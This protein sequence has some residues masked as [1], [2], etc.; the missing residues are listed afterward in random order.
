MNDTIEGLNET[1]I[2]KGNT[3]G[4]MKLITLANNTVIARR[5]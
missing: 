3:T 5:K 2:F 1:I 4:I